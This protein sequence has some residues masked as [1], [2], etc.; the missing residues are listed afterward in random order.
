MSEVDSRPNYLKD[1]IGGD[2]GGQRQTQRHLFL[3]VV[4]N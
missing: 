3:V 4:T 2:G 1:A